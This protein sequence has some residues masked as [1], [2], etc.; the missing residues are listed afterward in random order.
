M[1]YRYTLKQNLKEE[2]R[3]EFQN[4]RITAFKEVEERL[5]NIYKLVDIAEKE[6]VQYYNENPQSYA[7][8]YGTDLILDYIQDIEDLLTT[9]KE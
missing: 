6:T 1:A 8:V 9:N 3:L 7:V 4:R 2:G 5:N